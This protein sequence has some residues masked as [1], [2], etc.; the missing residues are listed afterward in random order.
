MVTLLYVLVVFSHSL[1]LLYLVSLGCFLSFECV[2]SHSHAYL[3]LLFIQT[4]GYAL[5]QLHLQNEVRA[6]LFYKE[7]LYGSLQV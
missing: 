3:L 7:E 1:F 5:L 6:F 2:S 4:I